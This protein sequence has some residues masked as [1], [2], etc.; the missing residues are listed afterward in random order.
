MERRRQGN[1]NEARG[2]ERNTLW[3]WPWQDVLQSAKKI[4]PLGTV[5][6]AS[7]ACVLV[8]NSVGE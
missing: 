8:F 3:A 2:M 1:Q 5:P 4:T 7:S 6:I